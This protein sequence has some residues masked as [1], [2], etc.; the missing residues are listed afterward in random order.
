MIQLKWTSDYNR[1]SSRIADELLIAPDASN[2]IVECVPDDCLRDIFMG[3]DWLDWA[4][5]AY[6]CQR[7]RD[8]TWSMAPSTL[9]INGTLNIPLWK[10]EQYFRAFGSLLRSIEI[11][12][13]N[14]SADMLTIL[15]S[16]YCENLT[17]LA[18]TVNTDEAKV[19]LGPFFNRLQ[20]LRLNTIGT[21]NGV[22]QPDSQLQSLDVSLLKT[23][24]PLIHLPNLKNLRLRDLSR[25]INLDRLD[26]GMFFDLNAQ[27]ETLDLVKVDKE[28]IELI[29]PHLSNIRA[30]NID[31]ENNKHHKGCEFARNA[32]CRH[33]QILSLKW[34]DCGVLSDLLRTLKQ[35]GNQLKSLTLLNTNAN[36]PME[37][38]HEMESIEYLHIDRINQKNLMDLV[39]YNKNLHAIHVQSF[40]MSIFGIRDMLKVKSRLN[41]C[42][43]EIPMKFD[44]QMIMHGGNVF[45]D[46][47]NI[48]EERCIDIKVKLTMISCSQP[49]IEVS[50]L[51]CFSRVYFLGLAIIVRFISIQ[52]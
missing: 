2:N 45:D 35:Q 44:P 41:Q 21:W 31:M 34:L 13:D 48:R 26:I 29:P 49:N 23:G 37:M 14:E 20:N 33:L 25:T 3:L 17:E 51:T 27:I 42:F 10:A 47:S 5:L 6:V 36:Y 18:T 1:T 8:V 24:L 9:K 12:S 15:I 46:I 52:N 32:V 7:F 30:L 16:M 38:I 40:Q 4:A 28:T 19:T 22:F 50:I 39:E 43:F 11:D